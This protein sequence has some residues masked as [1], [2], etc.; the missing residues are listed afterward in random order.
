[1]PDGP[2]GAQIV[3]A[4][5][6]FRRANPET[7]H[8]RKV[9]EDLKAWGLGQLAGETHHDWCMRM[10]DVAMSMQPVKLT[11]KRDPKQH[12]I[13]KRHV[14]IGARDAGS[15]WTQ[16]LVEQARIGKKLHP[17]QEAM[18]LKALNLSRAELQELIWS[19]PDEA[20]QI[21]PA[22]AAS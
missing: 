8:D 1:M 22:K 2:I 10:R 21:E 9:L 15:E 6:K 12:S 7:E 14:D 3:E 13:D 5:F 4:S 19:A 11:G 16:L 17:V 18:L 20:S